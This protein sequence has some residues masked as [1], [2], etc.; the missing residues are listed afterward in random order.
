MKKRIIAII[1]LLVFVIFILVGCASDAE[2]GETVISGTGLVPDLTVYSNTANYDSS[3][4]YYYVVDNR[5]GVVYL[6]FE[7]IYKGDITVM[8]NAD[9]TPVTIDQIALGAKTVTIIDPE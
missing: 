6:A 2:R 3:P 9:G 1:I 7:T 4:V 8:L 5:T